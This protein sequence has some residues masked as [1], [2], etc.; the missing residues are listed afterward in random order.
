MSQGGTRPTGFQKQTNKYLQRAL[1]SH[2]WAAA[3]GDPFVSHGSCL[4]SSWTRRFLE[5]DGLPKTNGKV[6]PEGPPRPFLGS[7][8]GGDP[9]GRSPAWPE[10][11]DTPQI[12]FKMYFRSVSSMGRM[13]G[14]T[15]N[16]VQNA[17]PR[18]VQ[19]GQNVW[20]HRK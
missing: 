4:A 10:C 3:G 5:T 11:A 2:F 20:T 9:L 7:G 17:F 1:Q 8:W 6:P 16:S 15:P 19:H 12:A 13:R 18:C 14:H